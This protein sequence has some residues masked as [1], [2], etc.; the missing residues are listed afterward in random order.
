MSTV[1]HTTAPEMRTHRD[2]KIEKKRE[3]ET[4]RR[5]MGI[6]RKRDE[7]GVREGHMY[8]DSDREI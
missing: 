3:R 7:K 5:K 8:R 4:E 1:Y 6:E 2:M